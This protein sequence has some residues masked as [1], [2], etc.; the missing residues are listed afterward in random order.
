VIS[1]KRSIEEELDSQTDVEPSVPALAA[2]ASDTDTVA[3]EF[4]QPPVPVT[5]YVYVPGVMVTGSY[6][7]RFPPVKAEG[8]D[9]V[10]VADGLPP[11]DENKFADAPF[12]QKFAV[13]LVPA[14]GA[15]VIV[16]VT[17]LTSFAHG[18]VTVTVY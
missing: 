2:A 9:H 14:L 12:E 15:V 10:P 1:E 8:P 3:V 11:S 16:T 5:V 18:A 13:P 17:E 6:V 7:P 4:A